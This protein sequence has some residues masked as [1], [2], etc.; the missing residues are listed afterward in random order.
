[1]VDVEVRCL[2]KPVQVGMRRRR[3]KIVMDIRKAGNNRSLGPCHSHRLENSV[4]I[5]VVSYIVNKRSSVGRGGIVTTGY[6]KLL[7]CKEQP[8][9]G[10]GN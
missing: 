4:G 7:R 6:L 3:C 5:V 10:T 2:V 1:M 8:R 9:T